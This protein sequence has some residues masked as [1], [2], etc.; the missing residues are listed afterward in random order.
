M[1]AEGE[2]QPVF[3]NKE[4]LIISY[5]KKKRKVTDFFRFFC[6][7]AHGFAESGLFVTFPVI[8]LEKEDIYEHG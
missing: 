6:N 7:F 1:S 3:L 4:V 5:I 2:Y 8:K